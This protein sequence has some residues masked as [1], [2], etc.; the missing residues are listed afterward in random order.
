MTTK[1]TPNAILF[2]ST[3]MI[4][5]EEAG[6][7]VGILVQIGSESRGAGRDL[8]LYRKYV[9]K[10]IQICQ[11]QQ[12]IIDGYT[13]TFD[14]YITD[15][16]KHKNKRWSKDEDEVLIELVCDNDTSL[17]EISTTLGRTPGAIK[18][19]LSNL[20]GT[21]RISQK[22]AGRFIGTVNGD[23]SDC[24]INGVIYKEA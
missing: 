18:T 9:P 19:R 8:I 12:E 3:Q 17:L 7:I 15:S 5:K 11:Q 14:R 4:L 2:D 6:E 10:L 13:K 24:E 23:R 20:V 1:T 22:V 21:K 16:E